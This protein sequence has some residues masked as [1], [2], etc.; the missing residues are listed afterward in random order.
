MIK[1]RIEEVDIL[2]GLAF[3]AVVLQHSLASFIY[4]PNV[5]T[6]E[7]IIS[8]FILNSLRFAV[9]I[10]VFMTGFSLYYTDKGVGYFEFILKRFKQI[11]IPYMLWTLVYDILMFF[12]MGKFDLS[13]KDIVYQYFNYVLT[14]TGFYHLWYMAMIIQFYIV[15]PLFK[16]FINKNRSFIVNT[17]SL[18]VF[19]I[20]H[21][22][23][24]YWYNFYAGAQFASAT[25]IL[26]VIL[27]Y[28]DRI[29][30]VWMFYFVFG[31]YFS[32]YYDKLKSIFIK[33]KYLW[34]GGF[35]ISIGYIMYLMISSSSYNKTGGYVINHAIGAPVNMPM[36]P[37][38][39]FSILSIYIISLKL[40]NYKLSKYILIVGK[41]S[42]GAYLAHALVLHYVNIGVKY[43]IPGFFLKIGVSFILGSVISVYFVYILS[44]SNNGFIL[45]FV[46]LKKQAIKN[47]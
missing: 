23:I 46:G 5:N 30:I 6:Y 21:I 42:F 17:I 8:A 26:K 31:A 10:F 40:L 25:G 12:I 27:Q 13:F 16:I 37:L 34:F 4:E 39:I 18:I 22:G 1:K 19:F 45:K 15:F 32:I 28:S 14:G 36:L 38:L 9:P 33:L 41:Y 2:R 24:L 7:G 35:I 43:I 29:F 3:L 11:V 44:K 20:A 47:K